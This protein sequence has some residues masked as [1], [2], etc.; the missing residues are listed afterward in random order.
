MEP[1]AIQL[2]PARRQSTGNDA[3]RKVIFGKDS[4]INQRGSWGAG[5]NAARHSTLD[6]MHPHRRPAPKARELTAWSRPQQQAPPFPSESVDL[7]ADPRLRRRIEW[8]RP[9]PTQLPHARLVCGGV[10]R[11]WV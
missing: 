1:D 11:L 5:N 6:H 9:M 8:W 10:R 3:E 2:P 7:L 4:T